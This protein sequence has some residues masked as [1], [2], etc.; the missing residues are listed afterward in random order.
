[1]VTLLFNMPVQINHNL[2]RRR[3]SCGRKKKVKIMIIA[4]DKAA[5]FP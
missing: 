5:G 2:R 1:M 3:R 4:L